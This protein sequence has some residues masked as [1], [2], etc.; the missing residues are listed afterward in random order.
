MKN[1]PASKTWEAVLKDKPKNLGRT[2]ERL[3]L[4]LPLTIGQEKQMRSWHGVRYVQ[5]R[6]TEKRPPAKYDPRNAHRAFDFI[7]PTWAPGVT[8]GLLDNGVVEAD[9]LIVEPGDE[10]EEDGPAP[11]PEGALWVI[12]ELQMNLTQGEQRIPIRPHP[13]KMKKTELPQFCPSQYRAKSCKDIALTVTSIQKTPSMTETRLSS[14]PMRDIAGRFLMTCTIIAS[15]I[16]GGEEEGEAGWQADFRG[17][18]KDY[19]R[20]DEHR[21]VVKEL[22]VLKTSKTAKNR[23]ERLEQIAAEGERKPDLFFLPNLRRNNFPPYYNA[24]GIHYLADPDSDPEDVDEIEI[25]VLGQGI[26]RSQP[27]SSRAQTPAAEPEDESH[28]DSKHDQDGGRESEVGNASSDND[29][30]GE[31]SME[32]DNGDERVFNS[33]AHRIHLKRCFASFMD[34]V[35]SPGGVHPKIVKVLDTAFDKMVKIGGDIG[36]PAYLEGH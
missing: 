28:S 19:S 6:L 7:D 30:D 5:E 10:P 13:P 29:L 17:V 15:K 3:H 35:E 32:E 33:E 16:R 24:P 4:I 27:G 34:V 1:L 22:T 36:K 21:S 2:W 9:A 23:T 31:I 20:T 26:S 25:V 12:I 18:R 14:R 11:V 8:A